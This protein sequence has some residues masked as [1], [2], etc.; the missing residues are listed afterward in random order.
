MAAEEACGYCGALL[1]REHSRGLEHYEACGALEIAN[2]WLA[3][4]DRRVQD[5]LPKLPH[6]TKRQN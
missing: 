6:P 1:C 3:E 5:G 4:N 2:E